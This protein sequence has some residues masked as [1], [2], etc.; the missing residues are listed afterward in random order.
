MGDVWHIFTS[1][2]LLVLMFIVNKSFTTLRTFDE[3]LIE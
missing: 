1:G 3:I 2:V